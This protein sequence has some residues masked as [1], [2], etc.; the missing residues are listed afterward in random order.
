MVA[1][2]LSPFAFEDRSME[3]RYQRYFFISCVDRVRPT[4]LYCW[5]PYLIS[6]RLYWLVYWFLF[7]FQMTPVQILNSAIRLCSAAFVAV[8]ITKKWSQ[9]TKGML[10]LCLFWLVRIWAVLNFIRQV[11]AEKNDPLALH[12]LVN[13]TC[14]YGMAIPNFKE[15]FGSALII[16]YVQPI[17]MYL[18]GSDYEHVQ[19]ILI[20]NT[21]IFVFG[22]SVT[23]TFHADCRR[24]WLRAPASPANHGAQTSAAA[25][26]SAAPRHARG[27]AS[28]AGGTEAS[29]AEKQDRGCEQLAD[30]FSA[31]GRPEPCADSARVLPPP[32][33]PPAVGRPC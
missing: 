5:F 8:V 26:T 9:S 19:Q 21:Y 32:S 7:P 14:V 23:W 17:C 30:F 11:S 18:A 13:F 24:D 10:G 25:G 29:A 16:A 31:D 27:R 15:Y 20:Q 33:L 12:G 1:L 4:L 2:L 22:V 3:E 28:N 6:Y